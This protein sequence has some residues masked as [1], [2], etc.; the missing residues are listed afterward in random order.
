M[1][2]CRAE[3]SFGSLFALR[4]FRGRLSISLAKSWL[5]QFI[6]ASAPVTKPITY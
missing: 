5:E 6:V 4:V 1:A 2:H 3:I